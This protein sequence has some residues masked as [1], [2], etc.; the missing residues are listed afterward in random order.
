VTPPLLEVEHVRVTFRSRRTA[1]GRRSRDFA[2]V[3]D[4]SLHVDA[5]ETLGVVGESGSGKSTLA[6][7]VVGLVAPA[8][9]VVR[10]E[11]QE[12]GATIRSRGELVR[13]VQMVFQDPFSSVNPKLTVEQIVAEPLR[14]HR[15]DLRGS[16]RKEKVRELLATA[17]LA[18]SFAP[19]H[20]RSLSG[21][22]LQRVGI[23]RALALDPRLLVADEPVSALDMSV[24]A[25]ILG[26][27]ADL[28]A[29]RNIAC[30]FIG[31][32]IAVV[33]H[34][35]ERIAVMFAGRIVEIGAS[36]DIVFRPQH[37]YT[38]LLISAVPKLE[39]AGNARAASSDAERSTAVS[40]TGCAFA[41]RCPFA[42]DRCRSERPELRPLADG[43]TVAC[44]RV[45]E[46]P[47]VDTAIL[48]AVTLPSRP[49]HLAMREESAT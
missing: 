39:S 3:D 2:A 17:H 16:A 47:P 21:G 42:V 6:R 13:D 45:H 38:R 20:P 28:K 7:A 46:L 34:V 4:V 49:S 25:Q 36:D 1:G 11:G 48:E 43:R 10:I 14:N 41:T 15:R 5:G 37:P 22:Q 27:F 18:P 9:G 30:L 23:A 19:R 32:N 35:A 33:Q 44:H 8:S 29:S 26:L 12:V 24:Q 40:E 31:H